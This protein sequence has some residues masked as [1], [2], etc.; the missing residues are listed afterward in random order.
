MNNK[1]S[2]KGAVA[3]YSNRSD[4]IFIPRKLTVDG[5]KLTDGE[6]HFDHGHNKNRMLNIKS[7]TKSDKILS[8]QQ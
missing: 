7:L 3:F 5:T 8:K 1:L 2:V 4:E 6:I